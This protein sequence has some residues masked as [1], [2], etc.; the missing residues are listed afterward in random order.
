MCVC[1]YMCVCVR[2]R[3]MGDNLDFDSVMKSDSLYDP[4]DGSASRLPL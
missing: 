1:V 2:V 3:G 4:N